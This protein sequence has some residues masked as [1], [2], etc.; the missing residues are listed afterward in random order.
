MSSW[1]E[2]KLKVNF[3]NT[4]QME[5]IKNCP[6]SH[7]KIESDV[8]LYIQGRTSI[9]ASTIKYWHLDLKRYETFS[10]THGSG[11]TCVASYNGHILKFHG[12][13]CNGLR[14]G[15]VVRAVV[16]SIDFN[17]RTKT[18][19]R[20]GRRKKKKVRKNKYLLQGS[21]YQSKC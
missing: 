14:G 15:K 16:V 10:F 21:Y 9:S 17:P 12:R 18:A 4:Q 8:K 7:L 2:K 20:K 11:H 13:G 3:V 5:M 19:K 1:S 6:T